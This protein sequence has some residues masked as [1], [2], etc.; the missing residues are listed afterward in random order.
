MNKRIARLF[1]GA[2]FGLL[3]LTS[4][5]PPIPINAMLTALLL[6]ASAL[7]CFAGL[8]KVIDWFEKI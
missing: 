6:L 5:Q 3:Y 8:Y 1:Y 2:D 7:L 4:R